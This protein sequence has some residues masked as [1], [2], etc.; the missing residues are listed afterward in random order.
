MILAPPSGG[1]GFLSLDNRLP[2]KEERP[3][4]NIPDLDRLLQ[5]P[6]HGSSRVLPHPDDDKVVSFVRLGGPSLLSAEEQDSLATRLPPDE[7]SVAQSID[8]FTQEAICSL[9]L[10]PLPPALNPRV[11]SVRFPRRYRY[12]D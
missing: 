6:R 7:S 2:H 5:R 8:S 11:V 12:Y 3:F 10:P 4:L 1:A 9:T